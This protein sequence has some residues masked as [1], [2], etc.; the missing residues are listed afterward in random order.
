MNLNNALSDIHSRLKLI[1]GGH[2]LNWFWRPRLQ[3]KEVRTRYTVERKLFLLRKFIPFAESLQCRSEVDTSIPFKQEQIFTLWFQGLDKAPHVVKACVESMRR[4]YGER[5]VV[6]DND[7]LGHF[8]QLPDYIIEKWKT[9]KIIPANFSDI[10]RIELLTRYGG[11]WFDATDF[12]TGDI[13]ERIIE[14]DFF[15]Y[16][17]GKKLLPRMFVQTCFVRAR[18]GDPLVRMWRDLVFEYWRTE[19]KAVDYFLVHM[20]FRLLVKHNAQARELFNKMP[21]IVMDPT[22]VLW[23]KL[24]NKPFNHA[25]YDEMV[26]NAFFQKCNY[27]STRNPV[28]V[29]V[30]GSF[31]DFV[32]NGKVN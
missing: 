30:E 17:T 12:L 25:E 9:G 22:H 23:L 29:I 13:P 18:K 16:V 2:V 21:K 14:S 20:L 32:I 28:P 1:V 15:M 11:V 31:A 26:K 6:L 19:E 27:K 7:S 5:V 3:R 10:C 8:I 4:R 24:G